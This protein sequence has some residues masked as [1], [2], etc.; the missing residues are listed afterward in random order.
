MHSLEKRQF[1]SSKSTCP[2]TIKTALNRLQ[3]IRSLDVIKARSH[4]DISIRMIKICDNSLI[5]PL[6]LLFKKSFDNSYFPELWKKSN[7]IP[8]HKINYKRNFENYRPISLF[9]IFSE[10][11]E[12]ILFNKMYTFLQSEHLLIPNQFGFRQS[13]SC[14]NQLLSITRETFQSFDAT[15]PQLDQFFQICQRL[16]TKFSIK[17]YFIN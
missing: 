16:L 6:S 7:N 13:D 4:D 17:G 8:V 3:L 11:F 14:M 15:P 12:K 9:P 10:I 5:R 2:N 1:S